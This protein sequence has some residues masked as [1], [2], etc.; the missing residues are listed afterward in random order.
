MRAFFPWIFLLCVLCAIAFKVYAAEI[1]NVNIGDVG[2]DSATITWVTDDDTDAAINYGLDTNFGEVRDPALGKTHSLSLE[3]LTPATT[4]HFRVISTDKS[5]NKSATAGYVFTTG[6]KV[7]E[8]IVSQ[9]D[10]VVDKKDLEK[11][12]KKVNKVAQDVVH[13]PSIIGSPKV[14]PTTD[15]AT[16]TW[17]TDRDSNS[18]VRLVA[19]SDWSESASD[20]YTLTQ[21]QPNEATTKHSVD[22]VGLQSATTY[23]FQVTSEDTLGLKGVTEDDM[24]KTK[25]ILPDVHNVKVSR[26]QE[27]SAL[28][29]WDTGD[30]KAK[31]IVEYTN[32]RTHVT[33]SAGNAIFATKQTLNLTGLEFGSRYTG[34]VISTNEGGE[35]AQSSPFSFITVRDVIPPV[36]SQVK[37]ESTLYPGEDTKVQTIVAWETDEPSSCQVSYT[38]GL[39]K[40]DADTSSLPAEQD[41]LTKHTQ[42]VVGFV[43]GTVYKFWMKCHDVAGNESQSDDFVLIT[44]IKEKNIIDI[45]LQNFQGTF[46]WVNK[47][48]K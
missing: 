5:G 13:P 12:V 47:I 39:I 44:P 3:G 26:V 28:I 27:H 45:I 21:G 33:K 23:H 9:L 41:P 48:G 25:S 36:I 1:S 18:M 40:S 2:E 14:V 20:P 22:V 19:E 29:T 15:G 10:K 37:N 32:Q 4:Y 17:T 42:V 34:I 16:I 7:A 24:F 30:V 31:G 35:N 46:G 38:Q 8:Q 11:I 43:A 6:G